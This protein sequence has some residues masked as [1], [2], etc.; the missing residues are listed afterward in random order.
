MSKPKKSHSEIIAAYL[1]AVISK[2]ASV[3]D[4]FFSPDVEYMVNG[5]SSPDPDGVLAP[6]SVDCRDALPWFGVHRGREAAKE[7]LAHMHRNLEV[8][9]F[10]PREVISEGNKAAAFGWF[11]L[12]ALSTGRTV[13]I[14]YSIRLELRDGLIVKY[15]FLENTF[16]VATAFHTGGEW[17]LETDGAKHL[18][19]S[20]RARSFSEDPAAITKAVATSLSI[21]QF[22]SSEPGAW[23]NSYLI[24]GESEAI[25]FDVSML[26]SDTQQIADGIARSGKNLKTVMISHAHPDH[27]LG[28]DVLTERFPGVRVVSTLNVIGDIKTDGPGMFSMLRD[29]LGREGPTRL[30]IPDP[31]TEQD[32]TIEG[33][34][35]EVVEFG[36]GES[37]HV[38]AAYIPTLT[39]LLSAD[40]VY[41]QAHLYL[42]EKHLESWL[43]RLDEL[44]TYAKKRVNTIHPG[45]GKAAGLELIGQTRAYLHDFANAVRSGNA[46]SAEQTMLEKYPKYHVKQFLTAF[47]IP[48]YVPAA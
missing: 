27:F 29:K 9:S 45:H 47:S 44:E 1:D 10:G 13:D 7:F 11:R 15:H 43:A 34:K 35:L 38:A 8:I 48:A 25:L 17:L 32:L 14:A 3:I 37:K 21:Q 16:D 2:D 19:P 4:R 6:L 24:S 23:S 39:A 40:L 31:L 26:Q 28:L 42:Q 46:E 18:V 36:E 20:W 33:V 22:T 12:H 5:T 30:V 41:N